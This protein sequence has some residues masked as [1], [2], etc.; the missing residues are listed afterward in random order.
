MSGG[1]ITVL[2]FKALFRL[3]DVLQSAKSFEQILDAACDV[4]AEVLDVSRVSVQIFSASGET[5]FQASRG[6]SESYRRLIE[7]R[8]RVT[9]DPRTPQTFVSP[10]LEGDE[11]EP[12]WREIV[13]EGI[14]ALISVPL[15]AHEELLGKVVAY[16]DQPHD[17]SRHEI[18]LAEM[19][20]HVVAIE[21]SR[22]QSDEARDRALGELRGA[23]GELKAYH[24]LMTHDVTN[25]AA[26]LSGLMER[27]LARAEG[28]L[29]P[30]QE[31]LLRRATRQ[32]Y[33]LT[34][35]ADNAK[36]LSRIRER[37][38]A[39]SGTPLDLCDIV[40]RMAHIVRAAHFD[41]PLRVEVRCPPGLKVPGVPF[42]ESVF[43]NLFDNAVRHTPGQG[44]VQ[45]ELEAAA[46]EGRTWIAVRGGPPPDEEL[47]SHLFERYRPG[48]RSTGSGLGL[49]LIREIVERAGGEVRVGR[50]DAFGEKVFEVT[51]TLPS[52]EG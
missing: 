48:A 40:N 4:L 15:V 5:R 51:L 9:F 39:P 30:A 42:I 31:T 27:L 36:Q 18:E 33:Q 52:V 38:L 46:V 26:T 17:F 12:L 6:L 47:L 49:A 43:L 14:R 1:S 20:A 44:V 2:E 25:F 29:T 13:A 50:A 8:W 16:R 11:R 28:A 41:R 32:V 45:V 7:E 24:D 37:G 34:R 19:I 23:Q 10:R 35:L 21:V 22:H 3:R